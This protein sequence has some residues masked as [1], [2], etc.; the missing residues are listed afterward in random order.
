V[1]KEFLRKKSNKKERKKAPSLPTLIQKNT[2]V[3]SSSLSRE[4]KRK[5]KNQKIALF[6]PNFQSID[7]TNER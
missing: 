4:R 5:R 3:S 7:P 6:F 1:K 2:I